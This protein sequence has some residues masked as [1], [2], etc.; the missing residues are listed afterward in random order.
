M[1]PGL[2]LIFGGAVTATWAMYCVRAGRWNRRAFL[3]TGA[4]ASIFAAVAATT[5]R[6][7][8]TLTEADLYASHRPEIVTADGYV[9]SQSCLECHPANHATWD[10]SYHSKMTQLATPAAV[11]GNFHDCQV[12]TAEDQQDY[13]L[14]RTG[15]V[16]RARMKPPE[17]ETEKPIDLPIVMTTGSHHMQVYWYPTGV[18]RALGQLPLVWL[19][20]DQRWVPRESVFLRPPDMQNATSELIRWNRTCIECHTTHGRP[21]LGKSASEIDTQVA[22]FGIACEACH[23]PGEAHVSYHRRPGSKSDDD[24]IVN[25]ASLP[26]D[27]SAQVCGRC[28]GIHH[29][30]HRSDY[31]EFVSHGYRY[32][33]GDDLH[34]SRQLVYRDEVTMAGLLTS[35]IYDNESVVEVFLD[36]TFWPDGMVRVSGREYSG[37]SR[38]GCY[39]R[40]ELSCVVCHQLHKPD[41][42]T[43]ETRIWADDQLKPGM[44]TD[45]SCLQCHESEQYAV[46]GHTH[47][48]AES[49]GSR[50]VNCHMSY[51][52]WGLMKAIR[53][54][55]IDSP[56]VAATLASGRTN[57]CNQCHLNRT[58]RWAAD[59][60]DAWYDIEPPEL[61]DEQESIAHAVL[62]ALKGDAGQRAI[63]AWSMG[64]QPAV[65]ASGGD[66]MIPCLATLLDDPYTVVRYAAGK[67]LRKAPGFTELQYDF[68]GEAAD[69]ERMSGQVIDD[70]QSGRETQKVGDSA[71]LLQRDGSLHWAEFD[72]LRSERNNRPVELAE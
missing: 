21:R 58:L 50:C 53:S 22:E 69:R 5:W 8:R 62:M 6:G 46:A 59:T 37:L 40:G 55:Q 43:R 64:W 41:D 72:R 1:T 31:E 42:D 68:V 48:L 39:Q 44:R 16:F 36:S 33:P 3:I 63:A 28:H 27:R 67:S 60:L 56:D 65:E 71:V 4:V 34:E 52:T 7:G 49:S 24:P 57:A 35:G 14:Y 17:V 13:H 20:E 19:I 29:L 2:V 26:H 54:H 30:K 38:S 51:T 9:S 32:R 23:G 47:H 18:G 25:P 45:A 66:W 61:T 11:V 15:D 12:T 70:W 10:D